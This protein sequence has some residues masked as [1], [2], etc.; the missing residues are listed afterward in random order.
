MT[1]CWECDELEAVTTYQGRP[2]C[3]LCLNILTQ[4]PSGPVPGEPSGLRAVLLAAGLLVLF[5]LALFALPAHGQEACHPCSMRFVT[6]DCCRTPE[7]Q[8]MFKA[9]YMISSI[10]QDYKFTAAD[11]EA[12]REAYVLPRPPQRH[13]GKLY[14]AET[15]AL[16]ASNVV[17]GYLTVTGERPGNRYH[18]AEAGFPRGSSYVLGQHPGALRYTA[19]MGGEQAL[20]QFLAWRLERSP[21]RAYRLLG[22]AVMLQAAYSHAS[23]VYYNLNPGPLGKPPVGG[24]P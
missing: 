4:S 8:Q 24:K 18:Y 13:P 10:S 15:A 3:G 19:V 1:I 11:W 20:F 7:E 5:L 12:M 22:H 14:W 9:Q 23:G 17:D 6:P 2:V 21:R 16:T